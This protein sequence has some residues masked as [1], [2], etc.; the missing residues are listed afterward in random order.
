MCIRDR[1][2]TNYN[3][4][5]EEQKKSANLDTKAMNALFC[6]LNKKEF[7]RVS[8]TRSVNQIWQILHVTHEGTNKV[9]ESKISVLVHRLELFKMKENETIAEMFTRFADITN[10]LVA[11]GEEYVKLKSHKDSS[12]IHIRL[13]E[14][15][16]CNRR[17]K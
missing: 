14:E 1:P 8:T 12:C 13:G 7:N 2:T 9:K 10:S 3:A 16:H 5:R 17:S 11:L 6:A 15:N 4:W